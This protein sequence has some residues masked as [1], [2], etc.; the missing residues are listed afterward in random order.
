MSDIDAKYGFIRAD[1]PKCKNPD[2][3][4]TCNACKKSDRFVL[5][6]DAALCHCGAT[7]AFATCTCGA[8]VPRANL[9]WVP[10]EKG[11]MALGEWEID[12]KRVAG[13]VIAL[14]GLI[15]LAAAWWF[16]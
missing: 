16:R 3:W 10:F 12:K 7:Y 14:A 11:P 9:V 2:V 6:P 1:C 8:E 13:L 4:L 15:A 5:G